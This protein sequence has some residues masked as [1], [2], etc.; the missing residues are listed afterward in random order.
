MK[1]ITDEEIEHLK[2][3]AEKLKGRYPSD[4]HYQ[5][6]LRLIE[7][8]E[9]L[10]GPGPNIVDAILQGMG[11]MGGAIVGGAM[12]KAA[13]KGALENAI[14]TENEACAKLVEGIA[15]Q[16]PL[17]VSVSTQFFESEQEKLK[18]YIASLIRARS[19]KSSQDEPEQKEPASG[20]VEGEESNLADALGSIRSDC[21]G[22]QA[23][24]DS[25]IK[26]E[27]K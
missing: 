21:P 24:I 8:I 20:I 10:K 25:L 23:L 1:P 27:R 13:F 6:I 14:E 15:I 3:W 22:A 2:T 18:A 17:V 5:D 7:K 9:Y 4:L 16:S 26:G 19:Q 12:M 11:L